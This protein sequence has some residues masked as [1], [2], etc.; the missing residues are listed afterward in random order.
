MSDN[1][2]QERFEAIAQKLHGQEMISDA[3]VNQLV[4]EEFGIDPI[5]ADANSQVIRHLRS[6][7]KRERIANSEKTA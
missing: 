4:A 1:R 2:N 6:I 3:L 7:Q 5:P